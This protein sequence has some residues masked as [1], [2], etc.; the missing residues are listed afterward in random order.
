MKSTPWTIMFQ[1]PNLIS[2]P[3]QTETILTL[4]KIQA[5]DMLNTLS[6]MSTQE[7]NECKTHADASTQALR[8]YY[9]QKGASPYNLNEA[10]GAVITLTDRS[11]KTLH[12]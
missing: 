3:R 4:R 6:V 9:Q 12:S 10:L 8:T 2:N 5:K 11:Q 7:A 1:P